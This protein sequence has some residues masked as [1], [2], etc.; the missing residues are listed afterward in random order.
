MIDKEKLKKLAKLARIE[1]KDDETQKYLDLINKDIEA[2]KNV[3]D[4]NTDNLEN[5]SNPYEMY[6]ESYPD[7]VVDGNKTDILM[8]T[9]PKAIYNFFAVPKIIEQN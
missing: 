4:V 1:I 6:L 5:L 8:K 9:A 3:F 2:I 7:I